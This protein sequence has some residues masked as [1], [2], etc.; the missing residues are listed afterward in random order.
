MANRQII[1]SRFQMQ[2]AGHKTIT[3]PLCGMDLRPDSWSV[4]IFGL[5]KANDDVAPIRRN[6]TQEIMHACCWQHYHDAPERFNL[7]I[8]WSSWSLYFRAVTDSKN[9]SLSMVYMC[10][11]GRPNY[12]LSLNVGFRWF[13]CLLWWNMKPSAD[14]LWRAESCFHPHVDTIPTYPKH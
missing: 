9:L 4:S 3:T 11:V 5:R 8:R 14:I 10:T 6:L 1:R 12:T 2:R 7:G 13:S